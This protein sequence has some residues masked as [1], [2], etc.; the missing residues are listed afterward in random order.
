MDQKDVMLGY[1]RSLRGDLLGKL[2]G[3]DEYQVRRPMT[4]TGTNL[5]GLVK[6][7]ASVELGYF[8][9]VFGR[10]AQRDLPWF[11]EDA[12]PDADFWVPAS[13]SRDEILELHHYSASVS[14]ATIMELDLDAVGEVP[15]W[16][17][18]RRRVT[19]QQILVHMLVE[20]ARHVGHADIVRESI[21]GRA[22]LRLDDGNLT[23]RTPRGWAAHV[24]RIEDAAR[25][26]VGNPSPLNRC[27]AHRAYSASAAL[28]ASERLRS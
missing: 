20:T 13:E 26:A 8:T 5:L 6:H 23:G 21:D 14:D 19:L 7:L 16:P 1:L 4:L 11:R 24:A 22:G 25:A 12:E 2:D 18:E 27:E 28:I 10:E 3:L 17:P 9:D 15:W